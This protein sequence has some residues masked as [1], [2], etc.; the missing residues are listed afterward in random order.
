MSEKIGLIAREGV[1][2]QL[3]QLAQEA[4]TENIFQP[5]T[6]VHSRNGQ[7]NILS[8]I[9]Y[10]EKED[11]TLPDKLRNVLYLHIPVLVFIHALFYSVLVSQ[12]AS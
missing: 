6:K 11:F 8:M 7:S 12:L 10:I 9:T 3:A 1:A 5:L 4:Y 2:T